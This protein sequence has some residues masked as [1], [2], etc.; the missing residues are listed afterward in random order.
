[1]GPL[2]NRGKDDGTT[3]RMREKMFAIGDDFWIEDGDGERAFKVNGKVLRVRDTFV[4]EDTSGA[5]LFSIQEKAAHPGHDGDRA[6]GRPWLP[7][8]RR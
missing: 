5:E 3:Y 7:S 4:L 6:R 1:M 8:R 2:R